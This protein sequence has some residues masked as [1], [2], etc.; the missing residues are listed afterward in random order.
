M[1]KEFAKNRDYISLSLY[2]LAFLVPVV[3][4]LLLFWK[5][6]FYPFGED[7]GK[8]L[9]IMDMK[10]QYLEFYASLR[11]IFSGDDSIFFSWSRSMGGNYLGLF[12]Y[13]VASPLSW[14]TVFFPLKNLTA[15]IFVLTLLKI[16]LCGLSFSVFAGY[17]WD[18][19]MAQLPHGAA[20]GKKF[21]LLPFAVCYALISYNMM[22]SMCLM[23]ID[24]VILLPVVLTG[25]EKMLDGRRIIHYVLGL[26]AI[27]ICNYYTGYMVGI[28]TG[29]Y[30]IFRVLCQIERASLKKW[31]RIFFRFVC[32]TVLAFALSAPLVLPVVKDLMQGKLAQTSYTPDFTTNFEFGDLFGKFVNGTYDSITNSGLPSIYCGWL[33]VF[34]AV[35]F[36][37]LRKINW[38]EKVGAMLIVA[39]LCYSFYNT[40]LDMAWHGFQYPTWFPYRYA[41]VFSFFLVYLAVRA[42]CY[43]VAAWEC[44]E[45]M[46]LLKGHLAKQAA[47]VLKKKSVW[48]GLAAV[49]TVFVSAEMK[50]NAQA[51]FEGLNGEFAYCSVAEYEE[52]IAETEPLVEEISDR[53]DSFYRVSQNYEFSK[54]DAMLYGYHG[55]THY[56][57]TY[58]AGVNTVTP[59]LGLAQSHI[60]N[61]GYGSNPLLDSLFAVKYVLDDSPVPSEYTKLSEQEAVSDGVNDGT[62]VLY[63]NE[64]ALP[65][66][67][68]A[69]AAGLSPDLDTGDVYQNQNNFLNQIAGTET[70]YYTNYD[71]TQTISGTQYI[72][73]FTAQSSNP[74]YLY[75]QA[76]E[77][78][79]TNVYVN[80]QWVGNYFTTETNCSLFLGNFEQGQEVTVRVEPSSSVTVNYALVSELHMD[81]LTG[82]LDMLRA[83]GMEITEHG[84]GKL[85]GEIT[86]GEGETIIT[87]IPYDEGWTVKLDGETVETTKYADAFLAVKAEPGSYE[88]SFSYVSPGFAPGMAMF[89]I[90]LI[91]LAN[92][93]FFGKSKGLR[94]LKKKALCD[95]LDIQNYGREC[96]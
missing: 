60:W 1:K 58:H 91:A 68:S 27:F 49:F 75:M 79:Y 45:K 32:G 42:I 31:G 86:V 19:S 20:P 83:G 17:L 44:N 53:D 41:F 90:A 38:K 74:V 40:R 2:G 9:F 96:G 4:M 61:S 56:S 22:Y 28:F 48:L 78:S 84:N 62:A 67:Y 21:L 95:K 34:F 85:S 16:G 94:L 39:F 23:W 52:A 18:R 35:V 73:T 12:A 3:V 57:S 51:I 63:Q 37:L 6:G 8:T 24:G 87:S 14:I 47:A 93:S 72:Y 64:N 59:K 36:L 7:G 70:S 81:E 55:M 30:F 80:E 43:I 82:T 10:D 11:N 46:P 26:T 76:N 54:N 25:L 5:L 13:Y 33:V 66:A 88:I 92:T 71:F 77:L 15:A 69:P 29:I 89:V 65:I 50:Q